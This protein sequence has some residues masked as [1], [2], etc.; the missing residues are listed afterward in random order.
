[1][2]RIGL[3]ILC[4]ILIISVSVPCA[5]AASA[6]ERESNVQIIDLGNGVTAEETT[7]VFEN[8]RSSTRV[9]ERNWSVKNGSTVIADISVKGTFRYD[10]SPVSV[11][12]KELTQC[13]TYDGWDF[14]SSS[15]TSSGGT[16]TFSGTLKKS[17]W[18]SKP[19]SVTLS[20]D[21]NGN[22]S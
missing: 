14:S 5:G 12:S 8:A 21:K 19:V 9:A 10:G 20:C 16:I 6:Y 7:T 18:S 22:I 15:L 1:M 3:T 2:K 4:F 11:V 13:E 17:L